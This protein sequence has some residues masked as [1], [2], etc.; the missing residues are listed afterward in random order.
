[1]VSGFARSRLSGDFGGCAIGKL[2]PDTAGSR[3]DAGDEAQPDDDHQDPAEPRWRH[4]VTVKDAASTVLK[5][6][7]IDDWFFGVSAVSA[8]GYES[9]VEFPG[10]AGSFVSTGDPK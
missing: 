2:Q 10:P 3:D 6:V 4:Q 5:D 1:M 7:V 8:D 9:P